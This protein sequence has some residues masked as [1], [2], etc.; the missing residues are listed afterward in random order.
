MGLHEKLVGDKIFPEIR[1]FYLFR[2]FL[3][4]I[5]HREVLK[6][7]IHV[8]F[9][10]RE[11]KIVQKRGDFTVLVHFGPVLRGRNG[12]PKTLKINVSRLRKCR[13]HLD[14]REHGTPRVFFDHSDPRDPKNDL[15]SPWQGRLERG[16]LI[17]QKIT[18]SPKK[19]QNEPFWTFVPFLGPKFVLKP[20]FFWGFFF[21]LDF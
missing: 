9:S 12:T 10:A 13:P 4:K 6:K 14:S 3:I 20:R 2:L 16:R 7:C 15:G 21:L 17:S 1:C 8:F 5:D 18:K 19:G 11:L